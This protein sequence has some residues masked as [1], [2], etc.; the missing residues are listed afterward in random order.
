M[1]RIYILSNKKA[2]TIKA[3]FEAYRAWA[4]NQT[5][6]KIKAIRTDDEGEYHKE[7]KILLKETD[8]EHQETASHTSQSNG[9][10][11]RMNRTLMNMVCPMLKALNA[12]LEL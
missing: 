12:S 10:S 3:V 2:K 1:C 7:M 8:I 11:K 9:V 4:E 6:C 5:G